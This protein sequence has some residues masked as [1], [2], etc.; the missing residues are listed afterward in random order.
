M[1][2]EQVVFESSS[3][4]VA[5]DDKIA[6]F[7]ELV[8]VEDPALVLVK[9]RNVDTT[10]NEDGLGD[11]GNGLEGTLDTVENGLEDACKRYVLARVYN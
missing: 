6:E 9:G 4:H 7:E 5:T 11:G 2:I 8:G 1:L 10:G 3:E